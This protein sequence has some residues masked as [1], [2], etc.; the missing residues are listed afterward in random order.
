MVS[1][2]RVSPPNHLM[3]LPDGCL[4][5]SWGSTLCNALNSSVT[6]KISLVV[7]GQYCQVL[8]NGLLRR[9]QSLCHSERKYIN[10]IF[11]TLANMN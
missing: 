7:L 8:T 4:I 10:H 1:N 2:L 5:S 9:N 3:H 11:T 6:G